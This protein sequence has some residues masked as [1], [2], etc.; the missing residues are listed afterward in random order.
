MPSRFWKYQA[1]MSGMA[2]FMISEGCTTM[3][4]LSQRREPFL[5]MPNSATAMSSVT[6]TV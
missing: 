5:M 4:M 6:P 3:P 1:S 2:I